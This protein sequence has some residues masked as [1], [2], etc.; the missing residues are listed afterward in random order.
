LGERKKPLDRQILVGMQS[1]HVEFVKKRK[2]L[3]NNMGL[4]LFT[5]TPFVVKYYF[6]GMRRGK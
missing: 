4:S 3:P 5:I 6:A 2:Q 1:V